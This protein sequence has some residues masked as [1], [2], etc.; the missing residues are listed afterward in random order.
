MLD[1]VFLYSFMH[2]LE[3]PLRSPPNPSSLACG[4]CPFFHLR[5]PVCFAFPSNVC[6]CVLIPGVPRRADLPIL[7]GIKQAVE[8]R[9]SVCHSAT[10]F[11][12]AVMHAGTTVDTFLRENLVSTP[13]PLALT[14]AEEHRTFPSSLLPSP[15][16]VNRTVLPFPSH[17]HSLK[18]LI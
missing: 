9:N 2:L 16:T 17:F 11:A 8:Y 14:L 5:E 12:N 10:I 7:K 6:A 1:M 13:T 15:L 4:P 3:S 18:G